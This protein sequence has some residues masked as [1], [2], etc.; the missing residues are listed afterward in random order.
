[1]KFGTRAD[2]F[3][4]RNT[5]VASNFIASMKLKVA[6]VSVKGSRHTP[7]SLTRSLMLNEFLSRYMVTNKFF[8]DLFVYRKILYMRELLQ[9]FN[10]LCMLS[11]R[12]EL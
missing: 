6:R 5:L 1:M 12:H 8:Y 4:R 7:V 3:G 11:E 9:F 10:K 2:V